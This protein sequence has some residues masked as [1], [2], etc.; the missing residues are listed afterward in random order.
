[1]A[2]TI[3]TYND[4]LQH[5][6]NKG[7][8][9]ITAKVQLLSSSASFTATHT[10][11]TSVNNSGAYIVGG[12]GWDATAEAI[13]LSSTLATTNDAIVDAT[14]VSVTASG[15]AIGPASAAV[16][17]DDGDASDKPLFYVDFGAAKQADDTT[18]FKITWD[19]DGLIKVSIT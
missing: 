19:A 7:A 13:T 14:D 4:T 5:I 10:A 12:N 8:D 15:G 6:L 16:I 2:V 9:G 3:S 17:Y 1:M 11:L 18:D